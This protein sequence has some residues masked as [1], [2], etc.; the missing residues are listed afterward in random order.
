[1]TGTE[2]TQRTPYLGDEDPE[3]EHL[4]DLIPGDLWIDTSF[5]P[6]YSIKTRNAANDGWDYPALV[7]YDVAGNA[8][9][10]VS[11]GDS[12]QIKTMLDGFDRAYINLT[13]TGWV[14]VTAYDAT[15][16]LVATLGLNVNEDGKAVLAVPG[17]TLTLDPLTGLTYTGDPATFGGTIIL[18]GE[19]FGRAAFVDPST[20]SAED[21]LNALIASGLM[22]GPP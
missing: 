19:S 21:A 5:G 6:A 17:Q 10:Q 20:G 8:M 13:S 11:T 12:V 15:G 1:M 18:G 16:S 22:E 4:A 2:T 3:V 9:T 7:V 14:E